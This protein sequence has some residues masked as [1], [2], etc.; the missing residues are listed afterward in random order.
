M[1]IH[2]LCIVVL[3]ILLQWQQQDIML[4]KK[5][6]RYSMCCIV[7]TLIVV[8]AETGCTI[9]DNTVAENRLWSILLNMIGFGVSPFVFLVE[10]NF[11]YLKQKSGNY[12]IYVPAAI[13][14][15][16]VCASPFTGWIFYVDKY[17]Q[18]DRGP[19]F[20]IYIAVFAFSVFVTMVR[21]INAIR[22]YPRY[23]KTRIIS[24]TSL[25]LLGL[26]IQ[27]IYPM[28]AVSWMIISVYL[29][30][31]YALAYEINGMVDGLT[32]LLN[33]MAFNK[34]SSNFERRRNK[35]YCLIMLDVNDFKAVNDTKGHTYGDFCLKEISDILIEIFERNAYVFRFGG[36]EFSIIITEHKNENT[37]LKIEKMRRLIEEKQRL[38]QPF[39][40]IAVGYEIIEDGKNMRDVIDSADLKMYENKQKMKNTGAA[41]S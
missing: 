24:S 3:L 5:V 14:L 4:D 15:F 2:I 7:L 13:N 41:E 10:S 33:R 12:L 17:C 32:G 16:F 9:V 30:L 1:A 18:Y 19:L 31:Y 39:P 23:F 35:R 6:K 8:L 20:L 27:I 25:M 22:N 11:Y 21:K 28:Y 29:V 36:D 37:E 40:E 26:I 34:M 38:Y